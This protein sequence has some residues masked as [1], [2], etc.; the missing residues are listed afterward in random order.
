VLALDQGKFVRVL[1]PQEGHL[2]DGAHPLAGGQVQQRLDGGFAHH[3]KRVCDRRM[4]EVER[5]VERHLGAR[6]HCL[7]QVHLAGEVVIDR[8]ARDSRRVGDLGQR[9]VTDTALAKYPLR[10]VQDLL[11]RL[12]RLFLRSPDHLALSRERD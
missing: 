10:G 3:R 4:R 5:G 9:S 6:Q 1:A 8:A 11:A 2:E 7:E 12:E